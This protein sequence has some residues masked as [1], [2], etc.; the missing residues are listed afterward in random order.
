MSALAYHR[1]PGPGDLPHPNDPQ[2]EP[3]DT[4]FDMS[5]AAEA[6]FRNMPQWQRN[7][8]IERLADSTGLL[9]WI[10][11]NVDLPLDYQRE[12][13][14]LKETALMVRKRINSEYHALSTFEPDEEDLPRD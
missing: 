4:S 3:L 7:E 5:D 2:N 13:A 12:F 14:D 11:R 6:T 9:N 10:E 1:M 8:V